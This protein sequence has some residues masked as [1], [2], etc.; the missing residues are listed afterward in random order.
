MLA[1]ALQAS[2]PE[3][4]RRVA[5]MCRSAGDAA[6]VRNQHFEERSGC[7]CA[8][9]VDRSEADRYQRWGLLTRPAADFD[10]FQAEMLADYRQLVGEV[11]LDGRP[12]P[13]THR[14]GAGDRQVS[15]LPRDAGRDRRRGGVWQ[16][17]GA[18]RHRRAAPRP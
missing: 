14:A 1:D 9:C 5:A 12:L 17:A 8:C 2:G 15:G 13:A 16:P 11:P 6:S 3:S 18:A 10:K 4:A 7:G